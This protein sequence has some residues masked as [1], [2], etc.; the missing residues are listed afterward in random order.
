M[1]YILLEKLLNDVYISSATF[2]DLRKK[3][4]SFKISGTLKTSFNKHNLTFSSL[5]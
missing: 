3:T 4:I 5:T 2:K 1:T